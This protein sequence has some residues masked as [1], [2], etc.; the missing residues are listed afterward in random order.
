MFAAQRVIFV[1]VSVALLCTIAL[2]RLIGGQDTADTV[3]GTSRKL[4][5]SDSD[6]AIPDNYIILFNDQLVVDDNH[7]DRLAA[8][9]ANQTGG[10]ILWTYKQV[11]KAVTLANIS[12][13][14]VLDAILLRDDV[15]SI[16]QVRGKL[17]SL[18]M[19]L[20]ALNYDGN[21]SLRRLPELTNRITAY[22]WMT[23]NGTILERYNT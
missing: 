22:L 5:Q 3:K 8:D 17:G 7:V 4:I 6:Q 23:T 9:L 16:E 18:R 12:Q 19:D 10:T 14:S 1:G 20:A 2:A 13:T 11:I 21:C 15:E